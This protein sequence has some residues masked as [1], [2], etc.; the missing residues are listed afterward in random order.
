MKNLKLIL[1]VVLLLSI[2]KSMAQSTNSQKIIGCWS[3]KNMVFTEKVE[4]PTELINNALNTL[5]CFNT[6]GKFTT[7]KAGETSVV[8]GKFKVSE[9]GK[10]L[11]QSRDLKDEG[12]D[13]DGQIV[14]IDEKQ[15]IFK[16]DYVTLIFDRKL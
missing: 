2:S 15:L 14:L 7:T 4:N 1:V 3:L 10:T 16:T 8:N 5:I 13:E 9:D 11:H 6:E 12:N